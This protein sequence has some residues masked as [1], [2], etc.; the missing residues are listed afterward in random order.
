MS[1]KEK[2]AIVNRKAFHDFEIIEKFEAGIALHGTEVKSIREGKVSFKDSYARILDGE[3]WLIN[4]H[5]SPYQHGSVWNHDPLR[6]RKLLLQKREAKRLYSKT[7]ERGLTLVP[8]RIYFK[9]SWAK[10]ELA[11]AQGKKLYDKRRD[12]AKRDIERQV[13]RELKDRSR[14]KM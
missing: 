12:I 13:H 6:K 3:V 5:I 4:L 7:E 1:K 14:V 2:Q 9:G 11:L 8:L 10:V